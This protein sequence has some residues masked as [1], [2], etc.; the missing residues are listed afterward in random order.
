MQ[1]VSCFEFPLTMVSYVSYR[2]K[3]V[4]TLGKHGFYWMHITLP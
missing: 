2:I 4:N 1:C 3:T